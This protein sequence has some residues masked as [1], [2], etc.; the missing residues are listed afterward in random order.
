MKAVQLPA[1]LLK[2]SSR[3]DRT[4]KVEFNTRELSGHEAATLLGELMNEGW[5]LWSPN[6]LTEQDIPDE[7]ADSMTAQKTQAQRIR[8][9]LFRLYEQSGSQGDFETYYRIKTEQIIDTLKAK[10]ED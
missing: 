7:K 5:L 4:Y 1:Q 8:G 10:L 9:V 2:V 6:E 3:A